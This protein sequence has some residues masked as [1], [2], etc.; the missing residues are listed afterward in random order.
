MR[1][2]GT[3]RGVLIKFNLYPSLSVTHYSRIIHG[4]YTHKRTIPN[5]SSEVDWRKAYTI[6]NKQRDPIGVAFYLEIMSKDYY[7]I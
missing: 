4:Q 2:F 6:T 3:F 7:A 1:F 5:T